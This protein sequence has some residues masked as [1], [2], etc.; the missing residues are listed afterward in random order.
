MIFY[1]DTFLQVHALH[2]IRETIM[3]SAQENSSRSDISF[4]ADSP[5]NANDSLG[6]WHGANDQHFFPLQ[7]ECSPNMTIP[8][9]FLPDDVILKMGL[10]YSTGEFVLAN[11][12]IPI[13]VV[14][15]F[16]GNSI[17]LL[18]ML[19]IK[20]MRT[21]TALYLTNLA[22]SDLSFITCVAIRTFW[23]SFRSTRMYSEP[24]NSKSGCLLNSTITYICYF[25]SIGFVTLVSLER[26]FSICY[27]VKHRMVSSRRRT[28]QLILVTWLTA[29]LIGIG[30][31]VGNSSTLTRLC[32]L[33]P[34]RKL[35]AN[36]PNSL[37]LCGSSSESASIFSKITQTCSFLTSLVMNTIMYTKIIQKLG[38]NRVRPTMSQEVFRHQ[39]D[40]ASSNQTR[41]RNTAARMLVTN[42]VVFFVCLSPW[43]YYI[44]QRAVSQISGQNIFNSAQYRILIYIG[45]FFNCVNSSINPIIYGLTNR[46]YRMAFWRAVLF[47][48]RDNKDLIATGTQSSSVPMGID[49][50]RERH[51]TPQ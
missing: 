49:F 26:F 12:M 45:T 15:G 32:I 24:F 33:W 50:R 9:L 13:I 42:G 35:Y 29:A 28:S 25:G 8:L 5:L 48:E 2:I 11:V 19:R 22:I 21:I 43:Q 17:F 18:T 20:E 10:L 46:R 39:E 16:V 3:T 30:L 7:N 37:I 23:S 6:I 4:F 47:A 27:P 38:Q 40:S 36:L 31:G 14:V 34:S 1:L 51:T 41:V 44:I